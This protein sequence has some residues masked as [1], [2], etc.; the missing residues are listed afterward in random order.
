MEKWE[1]WIVYPILAISISFSIT[2]MCKWLPRILKIDDNGQ[3]DLGFD[4]IGAIV[5]ILALLVTVLIGLN[6][7]TV[8]DVKQEWKENKKY[9]ERL[10]KELKEAKERLEKEQTAIKHYGY[11]ITD[12]CQVYVKLEPEK[13]NYWPTYCKA[14]SALKNFL[15]TNENLNWYAPA[16]IDNMEA[17]LRKAQELNEICS[18]EIS[19]DIRTYLNEIRACPLDGFGSYWQQIEEIERR[20]G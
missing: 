4:Y 3:L 18:E 6:I 1:R 9:T 14:L 5:G 13:K 19:N 15:N 16:C 7:W 8:I 17:A 2:V 20:R 11:A 12:F 10:E